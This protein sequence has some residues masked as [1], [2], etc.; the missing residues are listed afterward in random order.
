[1]VDDIRRAI[2]NVFV[3]GNTEFR[4]QIES[5]TG[6]PRAYQKQESRPSKS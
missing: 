1:M 6:T 4:D 5:I 2:Q 3:L